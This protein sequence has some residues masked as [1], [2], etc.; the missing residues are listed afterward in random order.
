[1]VDEDFN[2]PEERRPRRSQSPEERRPRRSIEQ[3]YQQRKRK[4]SECV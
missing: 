2:L 4:Q 1:M 3:L